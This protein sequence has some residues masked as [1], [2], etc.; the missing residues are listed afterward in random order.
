[1]EKTNAQAALEC[2]SNV[3]V[4]WAGKSGFYYN[5]ASGRIVELADTLLDWLENQEPEP[6]TDP[7]L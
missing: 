2:A 1:M 3:V 6:E 4:G 7:F 5:A